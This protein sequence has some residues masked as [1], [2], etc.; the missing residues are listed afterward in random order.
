MKNKKI[1]SEQVTRRSEWKTFLMLTVFLFP[2]LSLFAIGGYG[3]SI[4][5]LQIFVMGPPGH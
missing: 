4:W 2:T 1:E 3:F 5:F